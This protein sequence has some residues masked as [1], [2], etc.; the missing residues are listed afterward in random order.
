MAQ[1]RQEKIS[2]F[3]I[4]FEIFLNSSE[5]SV[6]KGSGVRFQ[7]SGAGKSGVGGPLSAAAV[8]KSGVG[9]QIS[10]HK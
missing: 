4:F 9:L 1:R 6:R 10:G 3:A 5:A 7:V 8:G 2:S